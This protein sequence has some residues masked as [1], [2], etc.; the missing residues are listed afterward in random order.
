MDG[1]FGTNIKYKYLYHDFSDKM[2]QNKNYTERISQYITKHKYKFKSQKSIQKKRVF[3]I[4]IN[5]IILQDILSIGFVSY[6]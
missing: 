2:K 6:N 5:N 3:Y 4:R 1:S